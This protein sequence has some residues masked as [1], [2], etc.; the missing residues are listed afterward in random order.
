M[1][2]IETNLEIKSNKEIKLL[3]I[4]AIVVTIVMY[5]VHL[6]VGFRYTVMG[7]I[8]GFVFGIYVSLV[9]ALLIYWKA[10]NFKR[11]VIMSALIVVGAAVFKFMIPDVFKSENGLSFIT[12]MVWTYV[13]MMIIVLREILKIR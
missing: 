8:S 13:I 12:S 6:E 7:L 5:I 1:K 4:I 9:T 3:L 11:I 2:K 10:L